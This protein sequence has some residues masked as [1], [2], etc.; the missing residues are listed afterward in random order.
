MSGSGAGQCGATGQERAGRGREAQPAVVFMDRW[1]SA[2]SGPDP[3]GVPERQA[4]IEMRHQES[5]DWEHE[6]THDGDQI[7]PLRQDGL[8]EWFPA[9]APVLRNSAV[10]VLFPDGT[11]HL[12]AMSNAGT[13]A[14]QLLAQW[15]YSLVVDSYADVTVDT[16]L[17][18]TRYREIRFSEPI[19]PEEVAV[20]GRRLRLGGV[21][22]HTYLGS[23]D[24]QGL[25]F[26]RTG[27][28][29]AFPELRVLHRTAFDAACG[30]HYFGHPRQLRL[31]A[32]LL[33]DTEAGQE[34]TAPRS[35]KTGQGGSVLG[36]L[37]SSDGLGSLAV[38]CPEAAQEAEARYQKE[39]GGL[40]VADAYTFGEDPDAAT[41]SSA[42][43]AA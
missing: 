31:F 28:L 4:T 3:E 9:E 5:L 14:V 26:R 20:L 43:R 23:C 19:S 29:S 39:F 38:D 11:L 42:Q 6:A 21:V 34:G 30:H 12:R 35:G 40:V 1:R 15:G 36:G 25:R 24:S 41:E 37:H 7:W 17:P 8:P 16:G 27:G 13:R 32:R 33:E 18:I 10:L 22:V 2:G